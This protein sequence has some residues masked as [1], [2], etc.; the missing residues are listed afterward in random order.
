MLSLG[1]LQ[2]HF[3]VEHLLLVDDAQRLGERGGVLGELVGQRAF[4]FEELD[5]SLLHF[6]L[7][8]GKLKSLDEL[9]VGIESLRVRED[10]R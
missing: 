9:V 6:E 5:N 10:Q 3:L 4:L 8:R 2:A 1:L 7:D